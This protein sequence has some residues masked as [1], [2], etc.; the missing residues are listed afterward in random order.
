MMLLLCLCSQCAPAAQEEIL[1]VSSPDDKVRVTFYVADGV[2][3]YRVRYSGQDVIM[4][5]RLGFVF[6]GVDPLNQNLEITA[7][8]R[9]SL[10]ETW[11]QPWG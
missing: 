7:S 2:P 10:D 11:E 9:Q 8:E 5:S 6:R 3:Y 1:T 4:P